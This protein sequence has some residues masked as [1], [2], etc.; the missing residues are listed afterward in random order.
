MKMKRADGFSALAGT[1]GM[2]R[3]SWKNY[4]GQICLRRK[5]QDEIALMFGTLFCV[6]ESAGLRSGEIRALRREQVRIPNIG[7]VIDRDIDDRGQIG[8]LK[9]AAAEDGRSRAVIIPEI[10]LRMLERWLERAP[11]CPD[12]PGLVFSYHGKP[13]ANY[14]IL[15][16]FRYRLK[17]AGIDYESRRLTIHCLQYTYNTRMRTL[18]SE[19]VLREFVGHHSAAMTD[20]YDNPILAERLLAYQNV[21]TS[22]EQF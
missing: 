18:L 13:V 4:F 22:V 16:R 17:N 20:H 9:N 1:N 12:Y 14:Y 21:R 6:T 5:E 8:S 2:L 7:L 19:Q 11:E 10:T 15:D 3:Y